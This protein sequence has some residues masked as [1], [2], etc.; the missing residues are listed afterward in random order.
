MRKMIAL[1]L[2]VVLVFSLA[3]VVFATGNPSPTGTTATD[4]TNPSNPVSPPTGVAVSNGNMILLLAPIMLLGV[5]GVVVA[6]KKLV[7]NH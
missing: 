1:L 4:P 2:I 6:T 3:S 7:K 5:F